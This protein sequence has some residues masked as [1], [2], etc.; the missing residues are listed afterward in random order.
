[1]IEK[2][3]EIMRS[4]VKDDIFLY[5]EMSISKFLFQKH[6]C[7]LKHDNLYLCLLN[8]KHCKFLL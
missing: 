8:N 1:M 5:C 7:K 4:R 6:E 2:N 3:L